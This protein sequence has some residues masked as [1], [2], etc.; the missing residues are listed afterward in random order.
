MNS[1]D[2]S[3]TES[4]IFDDGSI[5]CLHCLVSNEVVK[6]Y[7]FQCSSCDDWNYSCASCEK[8][9]QYHEDGHVSFINGEADFYCSECD[10]S[11]EEEE[12]EADLCKYCEDNSAELVEMKECPCCQF[13]TDLLICSSCIDEGVE[14]NCLGCDMILNTK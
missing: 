1:T 2:C 9:C 13:K 7:S 12:E 4:E 14:Y 5:K 10:H 3:K 11:V 6:G 8:Y